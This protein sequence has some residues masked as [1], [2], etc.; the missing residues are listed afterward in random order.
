[1]GLPPFTVP[2]DNPITPEKVELGRKLFLDRRLSPNGTMSCAMC[3]LPE[4]G[5]TSNELATPVGIE[6]RTVRRNAPTLLN[7]AFQ[8]HL[9]HDGRAVSLEAQIWEP[10]LA[11]N[12]MG[13]R[14]VGDVLDRIRALADYGGLFE[15]I[16][17]GQGVSA[18]RLGQALAAYERT[19]V[20]GNSR[21]DRWRYGR[22]SSALTP[23]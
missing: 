18:G 9:F 19:L 3:H 10:L 2:A 23:T 20:A 12:E 1:L 4:Q 22:D 7:V 8:R 14:S 16:F 13:N 5:F 6:G 11:A 17:D 15:K 21:F